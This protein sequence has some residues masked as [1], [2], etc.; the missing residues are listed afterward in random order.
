MVQ[1]DA[2]ADVREQR[3]LRVRLDVLRTPPRFS[4]LDAEEAEELAVVARAVD[5]DAERRRARSP[6]RR[7]R[8]PRAGRARAA[9]STKTAIEPRRGR[10]RSRRTSHRR[11]RSRSC[12]RRSRS[13]HRALHQPAVHAPE[14]RDDTEAE[15]HPREARRSPACRGTTAPAAPGPSRRRSPSPTTAV[16]RRSLPRQTTPRASRARAVPRRAGVRAAESRARAMRTR[17]TPLPMTRCV[18]NGY[19]PRRIER[20]HPGPGE[21]EEPRD[22]HGASRAQRAEAVRAAGRDGVERRQQDHDVG[23][24]HRRRPDD[25]RRLVPE[26]EEDDRDGRGEHERADGD[27]PRPHAASVVGSRVD[28]SLHWPH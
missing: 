6:R 25:E 5:D 7:R 24:L 11:S 12:P 3:V 13:R 9:R 2:Q 14:E 10:A 4:W 28:P 16:R 18:L 20:R 26:M 23:E 19:A 21:K 8:V 15:H 17:R 1:P 27:V 22:P